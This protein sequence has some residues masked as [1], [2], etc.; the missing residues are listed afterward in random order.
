MKVICNVYGPEN[1]LSAVQWSSNQNHWI[2]GSITI[3]TLDRREHKWFFNYIQ[4]LREL[5]DNWLASV[6]FWNRKF[7]LMNIMDSRADRQT[8]R[9]KERN[10]HECNRYDM[11]SNRVFVFDQQLNSPYRRF[12]LVVWIH[13][14]LGGWRWWL[15][16]HLRPLKPH[17]SQQS[18]GAIGELFIKN[19]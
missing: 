6:S 16:P 4:L 13:W 5:Q 19:G 12:H 10:P 15:L 14:C 11:I 18:S 8:M 2:G 1:I 17:H 7:L 9:W 3:V